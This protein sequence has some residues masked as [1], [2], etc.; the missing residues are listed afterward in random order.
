MHLAHVL[1]TKTDLVDLGDNLYYTGEVNPWLGQSP[2]GHA[3]VLKGPSVIWRAPVYGLAKPDSFHTRTSIFSDTTKMRCPSFS[4]PAGPPGFGGSCAQANRADLMKGRPEDLYICRNCYS[5]QGKYGNANVQLAQAVTLAWV[6]MLLAE[7]D[8][9]RSFARAM[10]A[11]L[12]DYLV[13]GHSSMDLR[14]FRIHDSGDLAWG[15]DDYFLAWCR[16]AAAF[17][18]QVS[19]WAP[20]RDQHS[21]QFAALVARTKRPSNFVLRPSALHF[22]AQ[23]PRGLRGFDAGSTSAYRV[24]DLP[25]P[26]PALADFDCP[27]YAGGKQATC[28]NGTDPDGRQPCRACWTHPELTINYQPHKAAPAKYALGIVK[29]RRRNPEGLDDDALTDLDR[30]DAEADIPLD[31]G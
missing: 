11:T 25:D 4:L 26:I 20:T 17:E 1:L 13:H 18:G 7:N 16:I 5:I 21:P 14:Y 9:G 15:R 29:R 31:L 6:K 2:E 28:L 30:A 10:V 19:F 8:G 12:S 24:T 23:A 22:Q 27:A 3:G